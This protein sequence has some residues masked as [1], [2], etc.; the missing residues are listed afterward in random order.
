[1]YVCIT[2]VEGL[3]AG[4]IVILEKSE[5]FN[6]VVAEVIGGGIAGFLTDVQPE[7][8]LSKLFVENTIGKKRLIGRVAIKNGNVALFHSDAELKSRESVEFIRRRRGISSTA[9]NL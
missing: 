1:M 7:G 8:C 4:D 6:E 5:D 9:Y 2:A 3:R